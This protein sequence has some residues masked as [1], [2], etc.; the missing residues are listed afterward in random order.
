MVVFYSFLKIPSNVIL[1]SRP[2]K[3]TWNFWCGH[4]GSTEYARGSV[5]CVFKESAGY[6]G[7]SSSRVIPRKRMICVTTRGENEPLRG[8]Q[9]WKHNQPADWRRHGG[10]TNSKTLNTTSEDN[11][12]HRRR[13]EEV[14]RDRKYHGITCRERAWKEKGY[15]RP[16]EEAWPRTVPT[17]KREI[18]VSVGYRIAWRGDEPQE[19]SLSRERQRANVCIK[20]AGLLVCAGCHNK[21]Q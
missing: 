13:R 8:P 21:T 19:G 9:R 7:D 16:D 14:L 20:T 1:K 12:S 6:R 4:L 15:H 3:E 17:L 18:R 10:G 5:R 11:G 2:S